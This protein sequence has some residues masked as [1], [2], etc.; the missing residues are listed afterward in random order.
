MTEFTLYSLGL[1]LAYLAIALGVIRLSFWYMNR[2]TGV[3]FS[4]VLKLV[5]ADPV[6]AAL[7]Y[8]LRFIGTV[9]LAASLVQ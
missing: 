9:Y 3:C 4:D 7:Y 6:A 5:N 2:T 1:N 8:G